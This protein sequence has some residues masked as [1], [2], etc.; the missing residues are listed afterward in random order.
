MKELKIQHIQMQFL[1]GAEDTEVTR[2][3]E[4]L[5]ESIRERG[6]LHPLAVQ[7]LNTTPPSYLVRAGRKRLRACEMIGH[8]EV[9]CVIVSGNEQELKL[10]QI[11][12]NLRR[13]NLPWWE[14]CAYIA[15]WHA[16]RQE[17][18]G[19]AEPKKGKAKRERPGHSMR[20]TAAELG[21]SL[22][23]ISEAIALDAAVKRDPVLRKI[24]DRDTAIRL[25]RS[26]AK[27][28]EAELGAEAPVEFAINQ[29]YNGSATDI[30]KQ[31]PHSSFNA[32][33][34]DPPWLK[35]VDEKL[36]R[37]D[38]TVP[39]FKEVYRV[40]KPDSFLYMFVGFEDFR[41]YSR[42]LP[43]FGFTVA[44]TPLFWV[45]KELRVKRTEPDAPLLGSAED[46]KAVLHGV[47]I[48]KGARAWEYSRDFELILLAV[49]GSPSLTHSTQQSSVLVYPPL[50]PVK[51]THPHEKPIK[52]IQ[53]ILR[54]CSHEGSVILDPFSG[55][56][57]HIEACE[58]MNR[59]WI[60]IERDHTAYEGIK[61]RMG[62]K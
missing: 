24:K 10:I 54:D 34:T 43:H 61:K 53:H 17:E 49:K 38:D 57:A 33:I 48:S 52:A 2:E 59:R 62:K 28:I 11:E 21:K 13:Y 39:V 58:S 8:M 16:L 1:G 36:T 12:E 14:I 56:G 7:D 60:A 41:S 42:R 3:I 45:K 44:K 20:D 18:K 23:F 25:V 29:V 9:P 37:D 22:G 51:L 32:C 50:P 4:E 15:D 46:Y 55:S 30:L 26:A 31:F 40:L 47:V 6:L 19:I 35:Y 5:S 27:R